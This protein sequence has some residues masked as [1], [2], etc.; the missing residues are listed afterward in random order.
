M[1]NLYE[2]WESAWNLAKRRAYERDML[3]IRRE[4]AIGFWCAIVAS[5]LF[6]AVARMYL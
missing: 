3:R 6:G 4:A 1:E 5:G 2:P